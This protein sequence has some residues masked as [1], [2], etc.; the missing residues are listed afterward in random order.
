KE[1]GEGPWWAP[2]WCGG[3]PGWGYVEGAT[4]VV[5]PYLPLY[6]LADIRTAI[7]VEV[8]GQ[9]LLGMAGAYLFAGTLSKSVALRTL[10]A[11][12]W[13][14]NGRWALQAAVGHTW[15]LQYAL[16][17]WAFYLFERACEPGKLRRAVYVGLCLALLV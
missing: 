7:R 13:V 12:L 5:S 15:H 10:L 8:F 9:A 17:P 16:M 1:Y 14:L 3:A 4:N 2:W 6:L 11:V